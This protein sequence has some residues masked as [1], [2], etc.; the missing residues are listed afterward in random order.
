MPRGDRTGPDGMGAM[1]GRGAGYC[2]GY[3]SPGYTKG[4]PRGGAGYGR[5]RGFGQGYGRGYGRGNGF[6]RGYYQNP[7]YAYNQY[8]NPQAIPYSKEN[9]EKMLNDEMEMLKTEMKNIEK[10]L[11][12]MKSDEE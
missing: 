8:P 11:D 10:R 6:G 9:E 4:V 5:G 12:A 1:T 7:N 3:S 2:A